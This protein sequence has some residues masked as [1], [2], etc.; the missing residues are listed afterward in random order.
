MKLNSVIFWKAVKRRKKKVKV[1]M[2]YL[3]R[4]AK[5]TEY[6]GNLTKRIIALETID[7][8]ITKSVNEYM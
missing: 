3:I 4:M 8:M 6:H 1:D 2:R 5:I 7:K